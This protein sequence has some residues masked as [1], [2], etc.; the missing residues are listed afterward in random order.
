MPSHPHHFECDVA[1]LGGGSAGYAAAR[2]ASA[3]GL[4]TVVLE[5]GE[6]VGGLCMLRGCMP[7]KALLYAA[8]A[9]HSARTGDVLGLRIPRA[10]FDFEAVMARKDKLINSFARYRQKELRAG[11]FGFLRA[12]AMF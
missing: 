5:G 12:N 8:E 7:S 2:T 6:K 4:R 3:A 1:V 9:L 11:K 10:G